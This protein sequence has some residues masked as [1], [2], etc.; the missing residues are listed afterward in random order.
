MPRAPI[1]TA[2]ITREL[3]AIAYREERA[4]IELELLQLHQPHPVVARH[5]DQLRRSVDVVR[6]A[7]RRWPQ[8]ARSEAS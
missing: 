5:I 4:L 8:L 7:S 3:E 6:E 2:E 1:S